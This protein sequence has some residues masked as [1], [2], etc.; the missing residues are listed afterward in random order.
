MRDSRPLP[1]KIQ[2]APVLE[3]G[4]ELYYEAFCNLNSCRIG[5]MSIG[6]VPWT[7]IQQYCEAYNLDSEQTSDMHIYIKL[8]DSKYIKYRAKTSG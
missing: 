7:A 5:G 3:L 4:L 8:M 6:E 2:N 1:D